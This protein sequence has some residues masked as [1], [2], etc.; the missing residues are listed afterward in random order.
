MSGSAPQRKDFK[1]R[2]TPATMDYSH[3]LVFPAGAGSQP[4]IFAAAIVVVV[5]LTLFYYRN[6]TVERRTM[7]SKISDQIFK[8]CTDPASVSSL[9]A[10][11]PEQA[12][13]ALAKRL[14]GD[15]HYAVTERAPP[16]ERIEATEE[17]LKRA[18]QCGN[19]GNTEP[20]ELFLRCFHDTL[21]SLEHDHLAG[22]I[23]P[24]LMGSHGIIPLTILAPLPDIVRH[25]SNL[26]AR[27]KKEV[28]LAT[29]FWV[30][31][32]ASQLITDSLLEL[33]RRAGE[34]GERVVVK[35]MYDRGNIKQV[36]DNHQIMSVSQYTSAAVKLPAPDQIPHID[37]EVQNFH[38]PMLGTFHAKY[39]IV[40]R[41][42]AVVQ[43][44]NIQDNDNLE[45]MTHLEGPIVDSFYDTAL[46][47]WNRKLNPPLP[48]F[49]DPAMGDAMHT[50]R[51]PSFLAM[52]DEEGNLKVPSAGNPSHAMENGS[53]RLPMHVAGEPHYDTDIGSEIRRMQ[54][55]LSPLDGETNLSAVTK[56][57]SKSPRLSEYPISAHTNRLGY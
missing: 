16:H 13:E 6:S 2:A 8:Y 40:D 10:H 9:Y 19:W 17:D 34:R 43:S 48:C 50:F 55:A 4:F 5:S 56:H 1:R 32:R 29:N 31:S 46:L 42:I 22:M 49:N 23:S 20:S 35:V 38:R 41:R 27:A 37:M 14:Y 26:I 39:M 15:E 54:S 11:D 45:K 57:L 18:R 24:S 7:A 30:S 21:C 3:F 28:F 36:I 52:F 53:A 33:S 12:P 44:N 25:M 47:S 51:D